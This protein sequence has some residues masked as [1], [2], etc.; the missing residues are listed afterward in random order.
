M[1]R[2]AGFSSLNNLTH[3]DDIS[4]LTEGRTPQVFSSPNLSNVAILQNEMDTLHFV[5]IIQR[6]QKQT[7]N[8]PPVNCWACKESIKSD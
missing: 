5:Q 1:K 2:V 8:F 6:V 7:V 4:A 3:F